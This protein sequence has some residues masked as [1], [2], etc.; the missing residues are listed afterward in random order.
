MYGKILEKKGC[1]P[2]RVLRYYHRAAYCLH[3]EGAKYRE[4]IKYEYSTQLAL[5]ALEVHYRVH[6]SILKWIHAGKFA[7]QLSLMRRYVG[8]FREH[9]VCRQEYEK[10]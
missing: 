7:N 10:R 4:K 2:S 1:T 8:I 3:V 6:A 5:E 9:G